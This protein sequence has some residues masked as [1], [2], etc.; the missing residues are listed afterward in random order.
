MARFT[1]QE[2]RE[3]VQS[4][5]IIESE[6]EMTDSYKKALITQLTVQGDTELMS[7]P[8]YY[9]P[10]KDA[11][12]TNT[13]V[14]SMAIIQDELGHANIAYRLLEDLGVSRDYLLYE[15]QPHEFK[16]PYGFD[17]YLDNWAELVVANGLFDRAGI[18]L[19]GDV[20]RNTSYG[21]LQRALVKVGLEENFHLRHGEVWMRRLCEAGGEAREKVQR[22]VDWMFPM[23]VEWFG[24]PDDKKRHS[25]QLDFK[26]K[27]MTN[28]ELRQT[29]LTAVVPLCEELGISIP[30]HWDQSLGRAVLDYEFPVD[31]DEQEKVWLLEQ[32][33]TWEQAFERWKHRGPANQFYVESVRVGRLQ[34]QAMAAA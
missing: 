21:P 8:S 18:T 9:G 14:S 13:M 17:Q 20:H 31:F 29:W 32:P 23:G 5:F 25:A 15:R 12:S 11:P 4:G 24:M 22:G 6:D 16:H 28:D 2:L 34:L 33:I 26:L 27:G 7:A 10:A 30:A 1:D 3:K 19:L